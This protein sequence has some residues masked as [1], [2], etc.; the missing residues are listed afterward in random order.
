[1]K[2]SNLKHRTC[3]WTCFSKNV[4]EWNFQSDPCHPLK[5]PR[6]KLILKPLYWMLEM[7]L[8]QFYLSRIRL[9]NHIELWIFK[10]KHWWK[11]SRTSEWLLQLTIKIRR[12]VVTNR[13]RAFWEIRRQ[14][15]TSLG[16]IGTSNIGKIQIT[17]GWAIEA[18]WQFGDDQG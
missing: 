3:R 11:N 17:V 7:R 4:P 12:N 6:R 8:I 16:R 14:W 5:R 1:M 13:M 18:A 15:E 9:F 2:T 10:L